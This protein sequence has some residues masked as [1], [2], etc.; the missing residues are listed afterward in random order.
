MRKFA[1]GVIFGVTGLVACATAAGTGAIELNQACV[2]EGCFE[3]DDPGFPVTIQNSGSYRLTSDLEVTSTGSAAILISATSGTTLELG[4]FTIQGPTTCTGEPTAPGNCTPEPLRSGIQ[5]DGNYAVIANG[6]VSGF[7]FGID[8]E[9]SCKVINMTITDSYYD[10]LNIAPTLDARSLILFDS[11]LIRNGDDGIQ[12]SGRHHLVRDSLF[13]ANGGR[14]IN[15]GGTSGGVVQGNS[16]SDNSESSNLGTALVKGNYF[17]QSSLNV[18]TVSAD[19]NN[20]N[21]TKC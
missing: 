21:G 4:G 17:D 16:V 18:G 20:C 5:V 3:G 19:D 11:R 2:A 15:F 6:Q 8:C 7:R 1:T 14:G 9:V 13:R 10:G 12:A